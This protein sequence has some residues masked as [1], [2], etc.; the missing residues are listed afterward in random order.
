MLGDFLLSLVKLRI[1]FGSSIEICKAGTVL[2]MIVAFA[3]LM[4]SFNNVGLHFTYA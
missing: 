1:N 4:V 2:D 3:R